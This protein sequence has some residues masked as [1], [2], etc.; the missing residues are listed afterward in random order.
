MVIAIIGIL[1]ALLLPAVQ[2]ARE[3]ARKSQCV[4]R[5]K[6]IGLGMQNFHSAQDRLPHGGYTD[7]PPVGKALVSA[8]GS[9]WTVF[10]L[11]YVEETALHDQMV[12]GLTGPGG[13]PIS[14]S[15]QGS[16]WLAPYNYAVVG[17]QRVTIY[18]CPS[19]LMTTRTTAGNP[20]WDGPL[21]QMS[22]GIMTN[23]Y[24]GISGFGIRQTGQQELD[25]VGFNEVRKVPS[26]S[27]GVSSGGGLLF[28]GGS[29]SFAKVSDGTS[30]T[31]L[32][33]EQND[34]LFARDG[35]EL[36]I[37]TGIPYGWLLGASKSSP[38][39]LEDS[40]DWRAHQC[41][42]VRYTINQKTGW[43]YREEFGQASSESSVN[44][45]GVIGSNI[46]LNSAHPGGVNTLFADG[47][48]RFQQ[49][50]IALPAL[51]RLVTRDDGLPVSE[52]D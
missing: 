39:T 32:V 8:W 33:S 16:G 14:D 40:Y 23:H 13:T 29:T 47:S 20:I 52:G 27:F 45:V 35:R 48:V 21:P 30:H 37:G 43:P 22:A 46:P 17:D 25:L 4:N 11:P 50:S 2:A 10:I 42:T 5:L 49:E 24:A 38:P 28:A 6:Q 12:F 15:S 44:G 19:S 34:M 41:T 51:A 7:E 3:A 36:P 9:A 18:Q 26:A 31:M 1:V